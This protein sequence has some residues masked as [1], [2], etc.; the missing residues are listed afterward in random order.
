MDVVSSRLCAAQGAFCVHAI[1]GS[2]VGP[3]HFTP[4]QFA[5]ILIITVLKNDVVERA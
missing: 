5:E 1:S 4:N 3:G 2:S